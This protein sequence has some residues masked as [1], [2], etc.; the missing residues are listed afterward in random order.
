MKEIAAL[1]SVIA[2][3]ASGSAY[4]ESDTAHERKIIADYGDCVAKRHHDEASQAIVSDAPSSVFYEKSSNLRSTP[5]L[6]SVAPF[7]GSLRADAETYRGAIA[8]ALV[9]ADFHAGPTRDF[10]ATPALAHREA[11]AVETTDKNSG[12]PV[13]AK[14]LAYRQQGFEKAQMRN[15]LARIGECVVR[16]DTLGSQVVLA[17]KV[18]TPD[19]LAAFKVLAPALPGCLPKDVTLTFDRTSLRSTIAVNY[20]RLA[21]AARAP[22]GAAR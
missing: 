15:W 6:S 18:A 14:T 5:C 10:S 1:V 22:T 19:E 20:Y 17:T 4:A 9:R 16:S 2:L 21:M 13:D 12:K 8:D 7:V 11:Y 3:A